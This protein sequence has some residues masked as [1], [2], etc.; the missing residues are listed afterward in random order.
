[1]RGKNSGN[2]FWTASIN[3]GIREAQKLGVDYILTANNDIEMDPDSLS[4]LVHTAEK[5]APC[6]VGAKIYFQEDRKRI[7]SGGGHLDWKSFTPFNMAPKGRI[8]SGQYNCLRDVDFLTGNCLLI[9]RECFERIGLYDENRLPHYHA[10]HDLTLR[11]KRAGFHLLFEPKAIVYNSGLS[12]GML[13][14]YSPLT[15]WKLF[16]VLF[17]IKSPANLKSV[18]LI[19]WRFCPR[20]HLIGSIFRYYTSFYGLYLQNGCVEN[21]REYKGIFLRLCTYDLNFFIG[22]FLYL[23]NVYENH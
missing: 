13:G 2:L 7:F 14:A 5:H 23:D 1:M 21:E 17:S 3:M 20:K 15:V 9:S 19:H 12:S 22:Y 8:D 10:D 18:F 16:P 6:L 4:A 11:A